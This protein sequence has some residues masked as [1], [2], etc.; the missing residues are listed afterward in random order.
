MFKSM[1]LQ[2]VDEKRSQAKNLIQ[3]LVGSYEK[4]NVSFDGWLSIIRRM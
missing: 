4:F 1:V 3:S 2:L